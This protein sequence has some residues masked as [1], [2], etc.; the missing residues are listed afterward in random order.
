MIQTIVFDFGGVIATID[1]NEAKKRFA[2]L[3]VADIDRVLDPYRQQGIFGDLEEGKLSEE[4][5]R[6]ELG[7]MC[8]RE[9]N[10][11][12]V[13]HCW[14]G[15][16]KELPAYKLE[17]LLKLRREGYRVVMLSNTNPYVMHWAESKEFSGD[18]HSVDFY[19][20]A[21]Y[22]SYEV[23]CMKPDENFFRHV[24]A[25]ERILPSETL[26]VDDGPRNVAAASELGMTTYC[27]ANGA[28]WT[29]EIYKYLDVKLDEE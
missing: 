16:M 20:D 23:G 12:E 19:F 21:M 4:G 5:Y 17:A 11:D 7:K 24:L 28:D 25:K 8:G 18:G 15:Y 6:K 9:L 1:G 2:D 14:L 3:G 10:F 27:P 29:K 13:K 22:R 26:F